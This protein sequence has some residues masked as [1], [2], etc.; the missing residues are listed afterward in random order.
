MYYGFYVK[1]KIRVDF[2]FKMSTSMKNVEVME[3]SIK[4]CFVDMYFEKKKKL[5][6]P[7]FFHFC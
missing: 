6:Q 7:F 1:I 3:I 2:F 5:K 4:Y